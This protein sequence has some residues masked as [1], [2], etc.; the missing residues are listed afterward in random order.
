LTLEKTLLGTL[1]LILQFCMGI[2]LS[3]LLIAIGLF[4]TN[5]IEHGFFIVSFAILV[6]ILDYVFFTHNKK[7]I[8]YGMFFSTIPILI[9]GF[10]ILIASRLH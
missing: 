7:Q 9:I 10:S 8:A 3:I 1:Q 2:L 4:L 5:Q 6:P